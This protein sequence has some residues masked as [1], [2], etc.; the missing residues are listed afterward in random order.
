M[1]F[2]GLLN[3]QS[4]QQSYQK[5]LQ[6]KMCSWNTN[7]PDHGSRKILAQEI[8]MCN[9]KE[10]YLLLKSYDQDNILK[11]G[12]CVKLVPAERSY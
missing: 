4:T 7:A 3:N 11:V 2:K 5:N 10:W 12:K 1:K 6:N 9:M 8:I